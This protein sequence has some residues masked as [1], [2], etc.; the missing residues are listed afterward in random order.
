MRGRMCRWNLFADS[1][2]FTFHLFFTFYFYLQGT[3]NGFIMTCGSLGKWIRPLIFLTLS[4]GSF[5]E[6]T[7]FL[8]DF[9]FL[10]WYILPIFHWFFRLF[11]TFFSV[12]NAIGPIL[13]SFVYAASIGLP[14]PLDG[15]IV[16]IIA[17]LILIILAVVAKKYLVK[18]K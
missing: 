4:S 8:A 11:F 3:L 6:L 10:N 1:T 17:S 13:G 7:L 5:L 18:S 15:R 2:F 12:G 16:F 9:L 14:R